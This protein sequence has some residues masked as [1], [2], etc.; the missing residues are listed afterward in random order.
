MLLISSDWFFEMTRERLLEVYTKEQVDKLIPY[1]IKNMFEFKDQVH[2]SD[3]ELAKI[4]LLETDADIYDVP[5]EL[6]F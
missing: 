3:E 2:I 5:E 1:S 6:L 4:G